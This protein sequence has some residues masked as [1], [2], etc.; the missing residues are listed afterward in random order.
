MTQKPFAGA[1]TELKLEKL[2]GYLDAYTTALKKQN[3]TLIY[4]GAFAGTGDIP[5]PPG[6]TP[7]FGADDYQPFIAGSADR[8]LSIRTPF[9]EYIFVERSGKKVAQLHRLSERYPALPNRITV[10][11]GDTNAEVVI[12]A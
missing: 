11:R 12:S 5:R 6:D 10:I 7:L 3:F 9:D 4:L 8:A 1:H 2:S